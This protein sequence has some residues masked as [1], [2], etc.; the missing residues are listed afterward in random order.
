MFD[1]FA[2][3]GVSR[4]PW[5]DAAGLKEK[6]REA[7]AKLHPDSP[8]G[9]TAAFHDLNEA[10]AVL[11]D[12]ARRLRHLAALAYPE[13]AG[14]A[15]FTPNADLFARVHSALANGDLAAVKALQQELGARLKRLDESLPQI[16]PDPQKYLTAAAEY[17]FLQKWSDQLR[18][19]AFRLSN[20]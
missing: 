12:P 6:F 14:K 15:A 10:F 19:R 17:T 1:A 2:A 16:P 13:F 8:G 5:V 11:R 20:R 4:H 3:M 7:A 9:D 18:E